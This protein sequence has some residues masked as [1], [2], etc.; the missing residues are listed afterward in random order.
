MKRTISIILTVLLICLAV[1]SFVVFEAFQVE[2]LPDTDADFLLRT[3]ISRFVVSIAIIWVLFITGYGQMLLF[4]KK[5]FKNVIWA[6][7]CFLVAVVNFPFF[8]LK[9]G[10]AIIN[11]MDLIW[12]YTAYIIAI[13]LLEELVF[14][15]I[16]LLTLKDYLKENKYGYLWTVLLSGLAFGLF[17]LTN[18]AYGADLGSTLLQCVYTFL[19]GCML[20][21][22]MLKLNNVWVCF[23]IHA[24]FDFGGLLV[25]TLGWGESW[26]VFFWVSTVVMGVLCA[27]HVIYTLFKLEKNKSDVSGD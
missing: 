2:I 12:L 9:N 7:P 8:T 4:N 19:I 15:G 25:L 18:L 10:Q 6:L 3:F 17:H 20:A 24:V 13:A 26:D 1:A 14:R 22:T 21:I 16:L 11:R 5:F 23:I 27:G